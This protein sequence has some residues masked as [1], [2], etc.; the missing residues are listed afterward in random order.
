MRV[1]PVGTGTVRDRE[2]IV[3]GRAGADRISG[4]RI[5]LG[6]HLEPVPVDDGVLVERILQLRPNRPAAAHPEHGVDPGV[7]VPL[8]L[9]DEQRR[10]LALE[11]GVLHGLRGDGERPG[12]IQHAE[13]AARTGNAQ[14]VG[15]IAPRVSAGFHRSGGRAP[16]AIPPPDPG[17]NPGRP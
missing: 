7:A 9:V 17:G 16:R 6:V 14:R 1:I 12:D 5:I 3:V 8:D 10:G 2:L 15:K 4:V 11:D 13:H